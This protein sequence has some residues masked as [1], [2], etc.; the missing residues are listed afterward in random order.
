MSSDSHSRRQILSKSRGDEEANK[1]QIKSESFVQKTPTLHSPVSMPKQREAKRNYKNPCFQQ[2][3]WILFNHL[4]FQVEEVSSPANSQL[5]QAITQQTQMIN[6]INKEPFNEDIEI[7]ECSLYGPDMK[8]RSLVF[9]KFR[10]II[11]DLKRL[12]VKPAENVLIQI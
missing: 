3:R 8:W 5:T 11:D 7:E 12:Q 10:L 4:H 6:Y 9:D 2:K 1:P